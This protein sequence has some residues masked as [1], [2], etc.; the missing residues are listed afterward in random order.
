MKKQIIF[1]NNSDMFLDGKKY[2]LSDLDSEK[3]ELIIRERIKD[4][5]IDNV[6]ENELFIKY[7]HSL[8]YLKQLFTQF[9][10]KICIRRGH[11]GNSFLVS[12]IKDSLLANR[13]KRFFPSILNSLKSFIVLLVSYVYILFRICILSRDKV[14]F[15]YYDSL[16]VTRSAADKKVLRTIDDKKCLVLYDKPKIQGNFYS[17]LPMK[18]RIGLISK[19]FVRSF[20]I[21]HRLKRDVYQKYGYYCCLDTTSFYSRR[22]VHTLAYEYILEYV[23]CFFSNKKIISADNLDRFALIQEK[24]AKKYN[25]TLICI[26][27]GIEYGFIL[28]HCFTGDTFYCTT[29]FSKDY[30]NKMYDCSKFLYD[31]SLAKKMFHVGVDSNNQPIGKVVYFSEPRES[32]VNIIIIKTVIAALKPRGLKVCLKLHPGDNKNDYKEIIDEVDLIQSFDDSISNSIVIARKS[33]VLIEALYN[34]SIPIAVLI[35][36]K[37]KFIFQTFPSLQDE[38]ILKLYDLEMLKIKINS[39]L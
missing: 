16:L 8:E 12:I 30:L 1:I 11:K 10:G 24:V 6:F 15:N 35:N 3:V 9:D 23:A 13:K 20:S 21:L 37:D 38:R 28:P 25:I 34:N 5:H 2:S 14:D 17:I 18:T 29:Q 19:A 32:Y 22:L 39:I 27:H 26:P 36:E 4:Y 7:S 33:T 31:A